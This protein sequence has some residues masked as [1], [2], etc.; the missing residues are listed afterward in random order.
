MEGGLH[1]PTKTRS[2]HLRVKL[3]VDQDLAGSGGAKRNILYWRASDTNLAGCQC[4]NRGFAMIRNDSQ[5]FK[6]GASDPMLGDE[7]NSERCHGVQE[8]IPVSTLDPRELTL[9]PE[10][11]SPSET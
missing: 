10:I 3:E 2:K 9:V 1:L 8:R 11:H 7:A 5:A 6:P 4:S